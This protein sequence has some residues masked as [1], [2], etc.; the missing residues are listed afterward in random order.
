M[1]H[2]LPHGS[3]TKHEHTVD[4][5][6]IMKF[7]LVSSGFFIFLLPPKNMPRGELAEMKLGN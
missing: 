2:I 6:M 5:L 1:G 3:N 4:Y 7:R